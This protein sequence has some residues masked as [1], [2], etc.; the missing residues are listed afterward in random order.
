MELEPDL[1]ASHVG[2]GATYR[3]YLLAAKVTNG[4]GVPARIGAGAWLIGMK[5]VA[6]TCLGS[7]DE[8]ALEH[9]SV[10]RG[11]GGERKFGKVGVG[12]TKKA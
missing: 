6:E 12:D 9:G 3:T 7:M 4:L 2:T 11:C 1:D 10:A 5:D 8:L